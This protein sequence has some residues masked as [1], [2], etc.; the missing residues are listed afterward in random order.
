MLSLRPFKEKMM[1]LLRKGISKPF[2]KRCF[3]IVLAC[4]SLFALL[5]VMFPVNTEVEYTP[6]VRGKDGSPLYAFLTRDQQW[7]MFTSLEEITPGLKKAILYKEDRYFYRHKGI[8]PFAVGRAAWNNIFSLRRT[9]GA[10]TITMQVARL[11]APGKRNYVNKIVEMFRAVQLE[12]HYSKEEILQLYLNLVPYGSNIQGVKAASLLYFNKTP[13]QL[14]LAELTALSV[15]PNRPNALVM[16]KDN[17]RIVKERNKWLRRFEAA[18]LFSPETIRDALQEP[19]DAY[20]RQPP[21]IA[22]QLAYRL[23]RAYPGVL[24]IRSSIDPA[25]QH[26]AQELVANYTAAL[27][28]HN[29]HNASAIIVD[30]ATRQVAAYIGSPDFFDR[31]HHGQVDGVRALRSPGS[32]L[33]PLLYGLAFDKGL[34]TPATVIA[35]IPVD[36]KGYA[37]ENYDLDFRGNITVE[38]A[39][40]QS[41]NI[42][43]VKLLHE[44][45]TGTFISEMHAAGFHSVWKDRKKLGLS[46]ILGGCGVRLDEMAALYSAFANEGCYRPLQWLAAPG[47]Q[48]QDTIRLLSPG[49]DY[50]LTRILSELQR[51]DLPHNFSNAAH[52]PRVAWK[53]G[54]SYGR[55]DAWSIGYNRRYTIAVWIGNFSGMGAPEINGAGT[56]TPL[57]FQLFNAIDRRY[58]APWDAAP[59]D[60]AYRLVCARTGR[61]PNSYCTEVITDSYL[62]GISDN[63][64]CNHL[65]EVYLSADERFSYCTTCLPPNGYKV[66]YYPDIDPE[67]AFFYES[68]HISY[69]KIPEHNPSCNRYFGGKPP[70][71]NSLTAGT[72]YLIADK[73]KQQL[74]LSCAAGNDV[75]L[76]YWYVNDRYIGSCRKEEKLFF[77]PADPLIKV[78]CTDD[79]GRNTDVRIKVRFI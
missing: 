58:S 28:L 10:S 79:K 46:L 70:V 25:L 71:I 15:I 76:V 30:N 73:G 3:H 50:M 32:A 54:T 34:A 53:T 43:A 36:Y 63:R 16:G 11:L 49:A 26:K 64:P 45:G 44:M 55:R 48:D 52:I 37:P 56:A 38:E 39:L 29:I 27:K 59:A 23:R 35:D 13:D 8:N 18:G 68:R 20:R 42:P 21:R 40:R 41:L 77:I 65:K 75:H 62:P 12:G 33:K 9:S 19:L 17:E 51:P 47:M 78:S 72:T 69:E 6:L 61:V 24:D 5:D 1:R 66:K 67:L 7:R 22:P 57:L 14:S 74:Q 60:L 2:L 31:E 4:C